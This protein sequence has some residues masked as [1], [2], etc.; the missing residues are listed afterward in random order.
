M[1]GSATNAAAANKAFFIGISMFRDPPAVLA[2][3]V[4]LRG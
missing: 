3:G 1:T 2:R 4:G